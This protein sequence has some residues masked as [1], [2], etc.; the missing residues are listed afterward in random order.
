MRSGRALTA[1]IEPGHSA[2][3]DHGFGTLS[4]PAAP[5]LAQLI[6]GRLDLPDQRRRRRSSP[7]DACE[8]YLAPPPPSEEPRGSRVDR[9]I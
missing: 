7:E 8:T 5:F 2:D 3:A 9:S 6:A 1:L 4:R